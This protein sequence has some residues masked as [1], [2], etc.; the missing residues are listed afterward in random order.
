VRQRRF[1]QLLIDFINNMTHEFKTPISTVALATEAIQRPDILEQKEKVLQFNQMIQTEIGRM[2]NQADKILQ[3]ATLE[4]GD[5]ALSPSEVDLHE[6]IADVT[7]AV[8]LQV[9]HA[10]GSLTCDLR[11]VDARV[12]CDKLHVSN[13]VHNLL[14]NAM[15]YSRE[16]PV[17]HVSTF[18][19]SGEIVVRVEDEGIGVSPEEQKHVFQ[20]Y[21]RVPTGRRHD[22]KGFGLGLSYVKLMVEAHGGRVALES[23]PG[24]GTRVEFTLPRKASV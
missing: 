21:Y 2:R 24:K 1:S 22:V 17:I 6:L 18:D 3:M 13:I 11:A 15:K 23:P 8:S 5:I 4:E 19:R 7:T 20:K 9:E 16:A 10:G 12:T 14:D